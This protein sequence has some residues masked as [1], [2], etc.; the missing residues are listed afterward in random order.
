[1]SDR[2]KALPRSIKPINLS[3]FP[4][5]KKESPQR[6]KLLLGMENFP[7]ITV[8][9]VETTAPLLQKITE[10]SLVGRE[11]DEGR[12]ANIANS[13]STPRVDR[14]YGKRAKEKRRGRK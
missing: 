5:R 14:T 11:D 1:M 12:K 8:R 2:W 9:V 4:A 3:S 6:R 13:P 7:S 10:R